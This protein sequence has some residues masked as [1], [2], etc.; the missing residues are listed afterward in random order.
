MSNEHDSDDDD[1]IIEVGTR[2]MLSEVEPQPLSSLFLKVQY[3]F[4]EMNIL[5]MK[6]IVQ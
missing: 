3:L 4:L 5:I 6:G 2:E 1:D